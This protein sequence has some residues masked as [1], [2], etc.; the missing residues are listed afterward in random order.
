MLAALM[1]GLLVDQLINLK[2]MLQ[3]KESSIKSVKGK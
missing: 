1:A 2:K 3:I